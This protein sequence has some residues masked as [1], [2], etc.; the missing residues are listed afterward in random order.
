MIELVPMTEAEFQVFLARAIIEYAKDKV[1]AGNWSEAESV[2]RSRLE[3]D[4][5]LPQ[6]LDTPGHFIRNI[7]NETR[8]VV[9]YLWYALLENRP[10]TAFIYDFEVYAA[11]RRRG[12]ASQALAALDVLAKDL[13]LKKLELHVFGHNTAARELYKKAGYIETNVN[14]AREI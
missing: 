12:Y 10:G 3:F 1:D 14:M 8:Q 13:G 11:Y 7:I 2:Q 5:Y 6:G 4:H 9:G